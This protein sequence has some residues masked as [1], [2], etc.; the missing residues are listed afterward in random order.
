MAVISSLQVVYKYIGGN[1]LKPAGDFSTLKYDHLPRA[2]EAI[3]QVLFSIFTGIKGAMLISIGKL[4]AQVLLP[5]TTL[6]RRRK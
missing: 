5:V 2:A 4:G 1:N 6:G 3:S